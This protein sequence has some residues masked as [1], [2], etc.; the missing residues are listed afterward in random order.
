MR[1][2]RRVLIGAVTACLAGLPA[3]GGDPSG[4]PPPLRLG[5]D[6]CGECGMLISEDRCSS[7]SLEAADGR[8]A[9]VLFDD[10]G[11]MLDRERTED[12]GRSVLE[13]YVHDYG[14]RTWVRAEAATYLMAE[15]GAVRTPMGSGIVAFAR[16]EDAESAQRTHGG[17]LLDYAGL[18]EARRAWAEHR[19]RAPARDAPRGDGT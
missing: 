1:T 7:G 19:G 17:R 13:R 9:Y 11:C 8:R 6:E 3:C 5:R 15:P 10:I 12:G 4:G 2:A 18:T 14:T 16:R